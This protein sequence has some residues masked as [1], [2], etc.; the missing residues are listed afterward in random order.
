MTCDENRG[1]NNVGNDARTLAAA[2]CVD[3]PPARRRCNPRQAVPTTEV[4][5]RPTGNFA[6]SL[7]PPL[8][9]QRSAMTTFLNRSVLGFPLLKIS[10]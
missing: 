1:R 10:N 6:S 8:R 7:L 2:G 9:R 4:F 5:R 3:L